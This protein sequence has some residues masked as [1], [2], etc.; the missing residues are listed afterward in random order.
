MS[1]LGEFALIGRY[2]SRPSGERQGVGDDCALIDV[3]AQ[4]LAIT[5]DLLHEGVHFLPGADARSLGH[6]ALAV[7]L[8]DLAAAG[9]RPRCFLLGLALPQSDEHWLEAFARGLYELADQ[10]Q[11]VL[12][13]GDTTR[14]APCATTGAA[15]GAISIAIT[16]L[17]MVDRDR[18]RGRSGAQAGDDI[19]VSGSLGEAALGLAIRRGQ[20]DLPPS[21][22]AA[23]LARM[24]RPT[25]RVALGLAL[26]GHISASIDIS[27]G[28]LGDLGHILER[29]G[30]AG[31]PLG[32]RITWQ[33]LPRP[34]FF[35]G[36]DIALQQKCLLAGGDDYE[37]LFTARPGNREAI[38][39]LESG[40][41]GLH[42]IGQV[43][44]APGVRIIG[45]DGAPIATTL[46]S[47]DHFAADS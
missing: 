47:F 24:D 31:H 33:A 35:D 28:L 39:A 26:V 11:C 20:I 19:W 13:G 5:T 17:G 40:D 18:Y 44:A 25:P 4:T 8:S 16:A 2:F 3:G 45:G 22:R 34:G 36:V 43:E 29:S 27:D 30:K 41:C 6:K 23:C 14:A 10:H 7:N 12:I 1:A 46:H 21:Q 42:R 32:A 37:L 38:A 15:G 9:A